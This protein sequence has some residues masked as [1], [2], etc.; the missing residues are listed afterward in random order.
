MLCHKMQCNIV[1]A[2]S[3][4]YMTDNLDGF[5][6]S[7]SSTLLDGR[8]ASP[9]PSFYSFSSVDERFILR[10]LYGRILNSQNDTYFLP[11]DSEEHRRLDLQHT[12]YTMS[13]GG[14]YP[15][16]ELVLRALRQRTDRRPAILDVGTGSGSWAIDMAKEFPHCDVV[17]VDLA[18]PRLDGRELPI[19]CRFE[20]D[21]ANLGFSHY[22]DCFDVVHAR[23][24][25]AGIRDF[26]ALL[27]EL[28]S[29]LRP[30]GMLLLGDGEQQ[31]YDEHKRPL[32][33]SDPGTPNFSWIHKMFFASYS[34][35]KNRGGNIDSP[36]MSPT[37]LRA[38]DS[39]TDVG[40]HKLFIPMGPWRY[41]D[42]RERVLSELCHENCLRYISGLAP[43]LLSEGYLPEYVDEMCR[44][45][46]NE[47]RELRT[48]LYTRWSF[49]WAVKRPPAQAQGQHPRAH[50]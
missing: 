28:A 49:A 18:P 14:L 39:L 46:S 36:S 5:D 29:V 16:P 30:G 6:D 11:A 42:E 41:D 17:G 1:K 21:D 23:A 45:A 15:A 48:R 44:E 38:I 50:S 19:N 3:S 2:I 32:A 34:A 24:I 35:M 12:Q 40:W 27:E 4:R 13:L 9:A 25:S 33:L 26:P 43:L 22:R 10:K 31:L 47:L 37:W 8:A 7:T 20:L